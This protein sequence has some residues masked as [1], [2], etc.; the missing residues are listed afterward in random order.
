MIYLNNASTTKISDSFKKDI[1]FCFETAWMNPSST[2]PV[3][4]QELLWKCRETAAKAINSEVY[5]IIFTSSGSESNALATSLASNGE[6]WVSTV[7]HESLYSI[8]LTNKIHVDENGKIKEDEL[9]DVPRGATVCIQYVNNETGVFQDI[10][11]IAKILHERG[12]YLHCDAVQ[13]FPHLPID[14]KT[15]DVDSLSISGHKFGCAPGCGLLFVKDQGRFK[16]QISNTQE[17]GLRGGTENLPYIYGMTNRMMKIANSDFDNSKFIDYEDYIY[18][19]LTASGIDFIVNGVETIYSIISLSF[20]GIRG[21]D[22]AQILADQQIYVSTGSACSSFTNKASHVLE[23]MNV[24]KDYIHGSIRISFS[25]ET[26]MSEVKTATKAIITAVKMLKGRDE[27][28]KT[29]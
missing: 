12:A 13:A 28:V 16:P 17:W 2:Y 24:P 7:E 11:K 3:F 29:N 27:D 22:L 14:V 23:A 6:L 26:T 20:R 5:Q 9:Y 21:L 1:Q 15:L 19:S 8:P 10:P 4:E 25:P 18:S